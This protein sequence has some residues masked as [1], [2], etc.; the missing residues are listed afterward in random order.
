MSWKSVIFSLLLIQVA[1]KS[2]VEGLQCYVCEDCNEYEDFKE[3]HICGEIP[4]VVTEKPLTLPGTLEGGPTIK[5]AVVVTQKPSNKPSLRPTLSPNNED[6]NDS[7]ES[8][9]EVS[10]LNTNTKTTTKPAITTASTSKTTT[11]PTTTSALKPTTA[12]EQKNTTTQS[13][14]LKETTQTT[15]P[16]TTAIKTTTSTAVAAAV[17]TKKPNPAAI[18]DYDDYLEYEDPTNERRSVQSLL[19]INEPVCYMIK[20]QVNNTVITNRGCTNFINANKYLTCQSLYNGAPMESCRVCSSNGCNKYLS[21]DSEEDEHGIP[22]NSA[23]IMEKFGF[24]V[25]LFWILINRC[26]I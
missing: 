11:K 10:V 26:V 3:L 2:I 4:I 25:L 13:A 12:T 1:T 24:V 17:T 9:D 6:Y 14:T 5:P 8:H 7:E 21:G 23:G 18:P 16:T 22:I 15:T 19:K 20:Y